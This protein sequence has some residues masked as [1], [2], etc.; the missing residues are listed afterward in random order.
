MLYRDDVSLMTV[1]LYVDVNRW[2]ALKS[3]RGK[4]HVTAYVTGL[5]CECRLLFL[6]LSHRPFSKL[7]PG[8]SHYYS[9]VVVPGDIALEDGIMKQTIWPDLDGVMFGTKNRVRHNAHNLV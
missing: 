4:H 3:I 9:H 1:T 6:S 8:V 7:F 5:T 2:M